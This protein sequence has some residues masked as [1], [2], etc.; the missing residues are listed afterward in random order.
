[1]KQIIALLF[2]WIC[3]FPVTAQNVTKEYKIS[4]EWKVDANTPFELVAKY[5][6]FKVEFWDKNIVHIDFSMATTDTKI[7]EED[8]REA[9][10]VNGEKTGNKFTV[11]TSMNDISSGSIWSWIFGDKKNKDNYKINNT[12]YLPRNLASL[13]CTLSYTDLR[14]GEM[15]LPTRIV[16]NYGSMTILKNKSRTIINAAYTDINLG[17]MSNVKI[18]SSYCDFILNDIDTLTIGSNYGDIKLNSC[19]LLQSLSINYGD[20]L[21]QKAGYVKATSTYSNLTI[22]YVAQEVNAVLTYSDI[23]LNDIAKNISGISITGT[24]SDCDLK[25]N[26]A[27]PV[28][29]VINDVNGDINMKNQQITITKKHETGRIM[30]IEAKTK[31]A[32]DA[33]PAI[34]INS[35][36]CDL[37]IN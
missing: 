30:T 27:N 5:Q 23:K 1:M 18:S 13:E 34:K 15:N 3:I 9:L 26:P 7:T 2:S 8:F 36:N 6:K 19:V 28:N 29:L 24:Y 32:V 11:T 35:K 33:S 14:I 12:I 16:T 31:S 4:K 37:I 21:I 10:K 25:I 17:D 20:V 22:N